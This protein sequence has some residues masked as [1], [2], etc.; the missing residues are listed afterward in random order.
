MQTSSTTIPADK[1][2]ISQRHLVVIQCRYNSTRLPGKAMMLLGGI[3]MLSFLL[4]RLKAG[5]PEERFKIILATTKDAADDIIANLGEEEEVEVLRGDENDVLERYLRCLEGFPADIVVRVTADNPFTCPEVIEYAVNEMIKRKVDYLKCENL[6]DGSGVDVF[7]ANLLKQ[8]G[9]KAKGL[10]ERE[11]INMY[12]L[13]NMEE[14][15]TYFLQFDGKY[16]QPSIRVTVD[17]IEDLENV[18]SI[19]KQGDIDPW[20]ISL[21]EIVKR[22]DPSII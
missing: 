5:L 14:Y 12:V 19:F 21:L 1:S 9:V 7:S 8:L 16:A 10:Q 15:A 4:K 6:P 13:N 2:D 17:T 22:M 18:R 11:H 20:R 3:P